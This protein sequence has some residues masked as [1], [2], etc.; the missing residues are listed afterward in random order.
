MSVSK[1]KRTILIP[2]DLD[3]RII[4][5]IDK[6]RRD[7]NNYTKAHNSFFYELLELKEKRRQ[8]PQQSS[9][10]KIVR[11]ALTLDYPNDCYDM[12]PIEGKPKLR[13]CVCPSSERSVDVP[14]KNG[15]YIVN[16]PRI[17]NRCRALGYRK[18]KKESKSRTMYNGG[19]PY[20]KSQKGDSKETSSY[21]KVYDK[22]TY[23][24]IND[25]LGL[26]R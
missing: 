8:S 5:R 18:T 26:Y 23:S 10:E 24:M 19:K 1:R 13:Q 3:D 9:A 20:H 14:R 12:I 16:D 7:R 11:K 17:C 15:K 2:K 6:R 21:P 22:G 4:S 25:P